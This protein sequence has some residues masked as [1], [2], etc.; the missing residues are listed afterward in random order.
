MSLTVSEAYE[1]CAAETRSKARNFYY[2][3]RL[4]PQDKRAAMCAIYARARRIDDIADGH[5]SL[6]DKMVAL[7]KFELALATVDLD[8]PVAVSLDDAGRRFP[9]PRHAWLD[10]IKGAKMDV[11]GT[12]YETFDELVVY[13]RRVAG[14]I[15]RLSLGVFGT[16]RIDV[17]TGLADDLGVAMQLTNILRDIHEDR[18]AGRVYLPVEDLNAFSCDPIDA[19]GDQMHQVL[20][21]EARRARDWFH[22]GLGLVPLLDRRSAACVSAMAGIYRRV[23]ARIEDDPERSLATRVSLPAWEKG[24]VA[25]RSLIGVAP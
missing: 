20:L 2:G 19:T 17:A 5:L 1:M 14:S 18:Q 4:L 7:E 12:R 9:I 6:R 24:V 16:D 23:L 11:A 13:C 25:A 21:F 3:I 8:D 10:L 22:V 15:G